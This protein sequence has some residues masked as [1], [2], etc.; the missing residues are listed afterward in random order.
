MKASRQLWG[1]VTHKGVSFY[2]IEN[3]PDKSKEAYT[4]ERYNDL[5]ER[6]TPK[7]L[8][9]YKQLENESKVS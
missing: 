4:L 5:I 9:R 3:D 1:M 2:V 6:A 7:Q 8:K